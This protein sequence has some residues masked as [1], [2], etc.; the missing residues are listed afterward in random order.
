M[1]ARLAL[2]PVLVQG[3]GHVSLGSLSL[4]SLALARGMGALG[5]VSSSS[6]G[7][8][9]QGWQ[10]WQTD[11]S[12][13]TVSSDCHF[14]TSTKM[15]SIFHIFCIFYAI[16]LLARIELTLNAVSIPIKLHVRI[17]LTVTR[18]TKQQIACS[19]TC[20][21]KKKCIFSSFLQP[22]E[23]FLNSGTVPWA[24]YSGKFCLQHQ[25]IAARF[26]RC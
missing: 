11:I 10:Y 12:P 15:K 18:L 23:I 2:C 4:A 25:Q 24:L 26:T 13:V 19:V 20:S 21:R 16:F 17:H 1:V 3:I 22:R 9:M 7:E 6:R 5:P 8:V 14:V